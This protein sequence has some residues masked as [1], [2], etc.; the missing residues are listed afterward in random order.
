L[1]VSASVTLTAA[2]LILE[3]AAAQQPPRIA[4]TT[5]GAPDAGLGNQANDIAWA[6]RLEQTLGELFKTEVKVVVQ[7]A[8]KPGDS[9]Q[10]V[11]G[12][13]TPGDE[14]VLVTNACANPSTVKRFVKPYV[15]LN[16]STVCEDGRH[17]KYEI[18]QK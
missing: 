8:P 4:A 10:G 16:E 14:V 3:P 12:R 7:S 18:E 11:I 9:A 15:K 13:E 6:R 2:T 17:D 1:T 5:S